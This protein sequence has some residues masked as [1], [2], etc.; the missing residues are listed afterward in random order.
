LCFTHQNNLS[1][2]YVDPLRHTG[3]KHA[4]AILNG[5]INLMSKL[6][7]DLI[8]RMMELAGTV[9]G[10]T[11]SDHPAIVSYH[12][13]ILKRRAS[14]QETIHVLLHSVS[15]NS[16]QSIGQFN[17]HLSLSIFLISLLNR[18]KISSTY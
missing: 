11:A 10:K 17:V 5:L 4:I 18:D 1:G 3:D 13:I 15:V 12:I 2:P 16:Y 8:L 9:A 6:T 7:Y 14:K